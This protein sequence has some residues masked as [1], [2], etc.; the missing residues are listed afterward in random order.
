MEDAMNSNL[1]LRK[2]I[3][4]LKQQATL[5]EKNLYKFEHKSKADVLYPPWHN[6]NFDS[7]TVKKADKNFEQ[8]MN[9][10][11]QRIQ[12]LQQKLEDLTL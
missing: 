3:S 11:D 9:K 1:E 10:K 8:R 5:S 12:N 6:Q 7:S 4:E 2:E